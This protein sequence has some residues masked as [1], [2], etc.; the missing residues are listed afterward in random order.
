M[1]KLLRDCCIFDLKQAL[2]DNIK[3]FETSMVDYQCFM[4][5]TNSIGTITT[6]EIE[7]EQFHQWVN[8]QFPALFYGFEMWLRKNP[9][10]IKNNAASQEASVSALV[11]CFIRTSIMYFYFIFRIVH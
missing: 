3:K 9:T 7:Q 2:T 8:V 11:Y 6:A 10:L 5:L 4:A 1:T